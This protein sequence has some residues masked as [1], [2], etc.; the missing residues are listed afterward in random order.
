MRIETGQGTISLRTLISVWTISA[1]IS[2]PGL[3][4][5]PILGSL[6]KI[7][8]HAT[9]MEIEMLSSI[10]SLMIIPF[11]LLS[12]YL[13]A[14]Y[15]R[16]K[17]LVIGLIIY[18]VS[19]AACIFANSITMLI[20]LSTVLGIGAGM[21][22]PL[23]TGF[24]ARLFVGKYRTAQLG[25][26]SS[27]SNLCLVF[28]TFLTGW[29]AQV[30][31][32]LPFVV[33]LLPIVTLV[34]SR[35][36]SEKKSGLMTGHDPSKPE[37]SAKR[38]GIGKMDPQKAAATADIV[39]P[40]DVAAAPR[41]HKSAAEAAQDTPPIVIPKGK[42]FNIGGLVGTMLLYLAAGYAALTVIFNLP[43]VI[44]AH[45]LDSS[46]TGTLTSIFFLAIMTPGLFMNRIRSVLGRF[47]VM[48]SMLL[49][50]VGLAVISL[51]SHIVMIGL[52]VLLTGLGYGFI[53]PLVYDKATQTSTPGKSVI[54]LAYV[55][56]VNYL[57][58]VVA[59][60]IIDALSRLF[61]VSSDASAPFM[62]SAVI[63]FVVAVWAA[64]RNRHF[65]FAI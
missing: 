10:P 4:V 54:A 61:G 37:P 62:I 40:E 24:I 57:T 30:E 38:I 42:N 21:V 60:F 15:D 27:I 36:L 64:V 22:I 9:D 14:G 2:L 63:A 58:I 5:S 3:A 50:A 23:S 16:V 34:M 26:S 6:T 17:I 45:K 52:G 8:P 25:I 49:I 20:V 41:V 43:F 56:A 11:I 29:L 55:M 31:W 53:Q 44:L 7:F 19:G 39:H 65:V 35:F 28:A 18:I 46:V 47:S 12:G 32:H 33:Y 48:V 13:S 51:N 59:P 1:I